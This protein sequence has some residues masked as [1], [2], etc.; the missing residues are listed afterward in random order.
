MKPRILMSDQTLFRDRDVCELSHI[1]DQFNYREAQLKELAFAVGPT[2]HGAR[3]VN[4]LLRGIPG[5]GKTSSVKRIFDELGCTTRRVVPVHVNCQLDHTHFMVFA[6][7]FHGIFGHTPPSTGLSIRRV[8]NE[9]GNAL[10]ARQQ[11]LLVCLDDANF[12]QAE[13]VLN[14]VLYTILRLYE[15]F[16]GV[17]S[18][19]FLTMSTIDTDLAKVLDPSVMSVLQPAEIPFPPYDEEEVRGILHERVSQAVYPGVISSEVFDLIVDHTMGCGDLRVGIDLIRRS[20]LNAEKEA[21]QTVVPGDVE[22]AYELSR[23]I[24]LAASVRALN[25][26]EK[27]LLRQIASYSLDEDR[28]MTS[29]AVFNAVREEVPMGYTVFYERLRKF[30]QMRLINLS[31]RRMGG[32]TREISLRYDAEK[33]AEE[34]GG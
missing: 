18:G 28:M 27:K 17:K 7:I 2:L 25:D 26:D 29:G 33:V 9:I 32:R 21:R 4:A 1:P 34:C 31:H 13:G 14:H 30:D 23:Y 12:I 6:R 24:H 22:A 16:P 11:V 5:T 15:E 3:P 20:V 8:M 19:V 10:V